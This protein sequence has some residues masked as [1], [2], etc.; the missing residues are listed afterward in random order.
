M[1]NMSVGIIG[2]GNISTAY[3]SLASQFAGYT[4]VACADIDKSLADLR[5]AEFNCRSL[6]V[7][8]LLADSTIALV[9]NLTVPN[10]HFGVS[11]AALQAG[12]HVYS[13][14]PYV[15]TLEQ[16]MQ[17]RELAQSMQLRLGSAPD[18]FLGGAHQCAR[19][20]LD[21][22]DIGKVVGGSC[23]FQSHGMEDWHPQPAFFYQQG[24]GPVLDMGPYYVTNLVQLL[25]PV[26]Q[27]AAMSSKPFAQ[28]AISSEPLAG[29]FIDVDVQTSVHGIL[30]FQQGAQI[31]FTASWDVWASENNLMELHGTEKSLF[32]PDPNNFGGDCRVIK[33]EHEH[34]H[35]PFATLS[36][37][38]YHDAAGIKQANYRG[39]GLADMV[40]AISANREHRCN[41]DLALHVVD[42]LMCILKA[43]ESGRFEKTTTTCERPA[44]LSD[45]LAKELINNHG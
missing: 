9:V 36:S 38:N 20:I 21:S 18:T 19:E 29:E 45:A 41:S 26:K 35:A 5:A 6:S 12:K 13:E 28:R 27:V 14:K 15:L 30:E 39:V 37:P 31:T 23:Y 4:I 1:E 11:K 42:T 7:D 10:A 40:A 16:G 34:V 25:G 43:A 24:G 32:L 44:A 17:L 3:L 33:G 2:C 8:E 22:G